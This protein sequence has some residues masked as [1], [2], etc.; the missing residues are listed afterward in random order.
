MD[1][2]V[3]IYEVRSVSKMNVLVRTCEHSV[4]YKSS[5]DTFRLGYDK[6]RG[7]LSDARVSFVNLPA[8]MICIPER[9]FLKSCAVAG[10]MRQTW[11][12]NNECVHT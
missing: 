5:Y 2:A 9:N 12:L 6:S 4:R 10:R 1:E 3:T 8:H 7:L 11:R